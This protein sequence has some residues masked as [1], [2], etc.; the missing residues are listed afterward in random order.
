MSRLKKK[1]FYGYFIT[2]AAWL[3]YFLSTGASSYGASI[4]STKMVL[5]QGWDQSIIGLSSGMLYLAVTV[6]SI[7]VSF[8]EKVKG[9][10]KTIMAGAV[11]GMAAYT[12]LAV[13][14]GSPAVYVFMF[15]LMGVCSSACGMTT[16]PALIT[17]WHKEKR[18][19]NMSLFYT[20]GAIA[21]FIMPLFSKVLS[22]ISVRLCWFVYFAEAFCVLL[23]AIFVVSDRPE[24]KGQTIDGIPVSEKAPAAA[25]V[26]Q[27]SRR[28][29]VRTKPVPA[30][31]DCYRSARFFSL[32][33][34]TFVCRMAHTGIISYITIY[35]VQKGVPFSVSATLVTVYSLANFCGRCLVGASSRM[36]FSRKTINLAGFIFTAAGS[37]ALPFADSFV[38][39]A[40]CVL[41]AGV[42][43]G[44]SFTIFT[45]LVA[46]C[47]GDENFMVLNGIYST[48]G[49]AGSA[50][51]P[52][53]LLTVAN[54]TGTYEIAYALIALL[55][56]IAMV[57]AILTPIKMLKAGKKRKF[58]TK[59]HSATP[60][61]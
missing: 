25:G 4:V 14:T 58:F 17:S 18:T 10:R 51:S 3:I 46:D 9:C 40:C 61:A 27:E 11:I 39:I 41:L 53:I 38:V 43:T 60:S 28:I 33:F 42:G 37:V 26:H 55:S 31:A 52:V 8:M 32:F 49:T 29:R 45:L 30:I 16:G 24:D 36:P 50:V 13:F 12:G 54:L 21:G 5:E 2:A 35:A 47:F 23:L 20:S 19:I 59:S 44:L 1:V 7:P 34:Q 6:I 56:G 57:L 48:L 22:D 15:F